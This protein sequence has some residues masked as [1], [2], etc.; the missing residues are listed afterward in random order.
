MPVNG[1]SDVD[2]HCARSSVTLRDVAGAVAVHSARAAV[3]V[4][5]AHDRQTAAHA[6]ASLDSR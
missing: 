4:D 1:L 2:V 6:A 3:N 5:L